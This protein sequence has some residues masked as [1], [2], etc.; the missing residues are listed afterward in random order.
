MVDQSLL[1][2]LDD[3][4]YDLFSRYIVLGCLLSKSR[5]IL[6]FVWW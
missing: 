2:L 6:P 1:P 3:L 5:S 4:R